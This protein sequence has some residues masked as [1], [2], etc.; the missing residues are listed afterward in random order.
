MRQS[1]DK[2]ELFSVTGTLYG[3]G[4]GQ[5]RVPDLRQTF[6]MG[7]NA[8]NVTEQV[9]KNGNADRHSHLITP[10][11]TSTITTTVG[12]HNHEFPKRWY[13]KDFGGVGHSGLDTDG[14]DVKE[15]GTEY[16]GS[17][18]HLVTVKAPV[19]RSDTYTGDNRPKWLAMNY[20]IKY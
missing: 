18:H 9:G 20:I 15:I 6:V 17:H 12:Y 4:N 3:G 11:E 14:T 10:P 7:A 2:S 19:F 5:F 1:G 8:A 16:A 13:K